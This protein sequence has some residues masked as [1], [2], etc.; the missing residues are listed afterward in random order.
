M[1][2]GLAG[3]AFVGKSTVAEYLRDRYGYQIL[4]YATPLKEALIT[5]TSLHRDNFYTEEGKLRPRTLFGG[6][7]PRE[8]MQLFGTEFCRNMIVQDFWLR[9]MKGR[10]LGI[11]GDAVIDDVRFQDEG[12][13]ITR[14]GGVVINLTR[15]DVEF[16]G[17]HASEVGIDSN[18]SI[19]LPQGIAEANIFLDRE[20]RGYGII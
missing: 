5:L 11:E 8:V 13:L 2:I 17:N 18:Y 12:H 7:T 4:S 20:L 14:A 10:L 19:A 15:E 3:P 16:E 1:I 6:K 9:L